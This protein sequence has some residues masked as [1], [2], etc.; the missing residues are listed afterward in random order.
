MVG[1]N[2]PSI[3]QLINIHSRESGVNLGLKR[4]P[5]N[6]KLWEWFYNVADFKKSDSLVYDYFRHQM[7]MSMVGIWL[8]FIDGHLLPY[9]GKEKVHY[10]YNTQRRMPM[11]CRTNVWLRFFYELIDGGT[12]FVT[13]DK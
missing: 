3:K 2:T 11:L 5:S 12:P 6:P 4:L 10:S 7:G 8:W 9:I 1:R 13:W